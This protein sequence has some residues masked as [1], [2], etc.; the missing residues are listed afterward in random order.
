MTDPT[1]RFS[2]RVDDYVRYRPRYPEAA[3]GILRDRCALGPGSVIAD[4]GSGTGILSEELLRLGCR[5]F[6]VEP[7][8][9]M[10]EAGE[11]LLAAHPGFASVDGRAEATTLPDACADLVAAG[12]AFHWFDRPR[13]RAEFVRVLRPGGWVALLWNKR[14]KSGSPLAEGNEK[15]LL[16]HAADYASVDHEN[17]TDEIIAEFFRPGFVEPHSFENHRTLDWETLAGYVRS[18][19]YVPAPGHPQFEPMFAG[20]GAVFDRCAVAGRAVLEVDTLVYLGKL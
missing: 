9:E 18:A 15:L 19:S 20:L 16:E 14:R 6:G 7:N 4:V 12:Q 13:T 5:V 2:S 8:R 17:V 11:R 3:I 10:R 1:K